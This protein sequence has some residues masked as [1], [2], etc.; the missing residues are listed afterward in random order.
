MRSS[1]SRSC[2]LRTNLCVAARR[3][4]ELSD[5]R[6]IC[7][8]IM[9]AEVARC[10]SEPS[11][12]R[13]RALDGRPAHEENV[14]QTAAL[15]ASATATGPLLRTLAAVCEARPPNLSIANDART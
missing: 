2:D 12:G 11:G 9:C 3:S 8:F 1:A 7:E 14:G 10:F 5:S 15:H 4:E 13:T 6:T